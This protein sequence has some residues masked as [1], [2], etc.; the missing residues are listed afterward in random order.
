MAY[1]GKGYQFEDDRDVATGY[2][3]PIDKGHPVRLHYLSDSWRAIDDGSGGLRHFKRT[4]GVY[5]LTGIYAA[6]GYKI[7]LEL[8]NRG[9]VEQVHDN[10]GQVAIFTYETANETDTQVLTSIEID[11]D[12]PST[13]YDANLF[14][15]EY[16]LDYT[17]NENTY[18]PMRL[19][20]AKVEFT[21]IANETT[22]TTAEYAYNVEGVFPPQ[23]TE[24]RDGRVDGN[25]NTFP[26]ATFSYRPDGQLGISKVLSSSHVG[27][28]DGYTFTDTS[29]TNALGHTTVYEFADV[30]G[31]SRITNVDGVAT[32][33]CLATTKSLDYTPGA[34]EPEGYIYSRTEKNGSVTNYTPQ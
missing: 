26:Y 9:R 3:A 4:G 29:A 31:Q 16:R 27:G 14:D 22:E 24:V 6:D 33:N 11:V 13:P 21:D 23:L 15:P 17:Y 10:K 12:H 1:D 20:L 8:D 25:G 2:Y 19:L 32:P 30:N 34:D 18:M 7:D 28:A 5:R